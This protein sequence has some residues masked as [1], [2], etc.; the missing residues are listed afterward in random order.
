MSRLQPVPAKCRLFILVAAASPR[1]TAR[2]VLATASRMVVV[3]TAVASPDVEIMNMKQLP[4]RVIVYLSTISLVVLLGANC[5]GVESSE[6][7]TDQAITTVRRAY[8]QTTS[9]LMPTQI[10]HVF[11]TDGSFD[12][13]GANIECKSENLS[14]MPTM[15]AVITGNGIN[16]H[17]GPV[18]KEDVA[19]YDI[20]YGSWLT[21]GPSPSDS[22]GTISLVETWSGNP[23]TGQDN[24]NW[25]RI[26]STYGDNSGNVSGHATLKK[27]AFDE[28]SAGTALSTNDGT[29][30]GVVARA[31]NSGRLP[32]NPNGVYFVFT[33]SEVNVTT[34]SAVFCSQFCGFHNH[35]TINGVDIKYAFV[36]NPDRCP[37]ACEPQFPM[38]PNN[39]PAADGMV[40]VMAHEL[41]ETISD[42]DLNAWFDSSGN[43]NAD[44]CVFKY[45][46][47]QVDA[48]G[49][50]Y[51]Q[52]IPGT[53]VG[54]H[55]LIQ[56][57]WENS[58]GGGCSQRLGGP[59]FN[60]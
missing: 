54:F 17:G 24:S 1:R 18:M 50:R 32:L 19:I 35:T 41:V 3:T 52:T 55:W 5:V 2:G 30:Q 21:G 34:G 27:D 38:S 11:T 59:F 6:K 12:P 60:N 8:D 14:N 4:N 57:N 36:G 43:E 16:Y 28:F 53:A 51:N 23:A 47:V 42:P 44:K 49:A 26:N 31:I 15:D 13:Y 58:R 25:E 46:P 29:L 7:T 40:N 45:G 56:M 37:Q 9:A 39:N 20:L 22:G 10:N 33:T 48:N